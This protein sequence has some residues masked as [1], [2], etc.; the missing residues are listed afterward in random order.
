MIGHHYVT[1]FLAVLGLMSL[2]RA[3]AEC[4]I[5]SLGCVDP[6]SALPQ[7][8]NMTNADMQSFCSN[9]ARRDPCV[10]GQGCEK[11]NEMMKEGQ[12]DAINYACKEASQ[13]LISASVC[14]NK[15]A[16]ISAIQQ[17]RIQFGRFSFSRNKLCKSISDLVNCFSENIATCAQETKD[18]WSN[19]WQK[20]VTPLTRFIRCRKTAANLMEDELSAEQEQ[21]LLGSG[22]SATVAQT[23]LLVCLVIAAA[24]FISA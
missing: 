22:S 9:T 1:I 16:V 17:C 20:Y 3:S 23:S 21:Q 7:K 15:Q 19:Y 12:E 24:G 10:M 5:A 13:D 6:S 2:R 14:F 18:F 4:Q 11:G 8:P